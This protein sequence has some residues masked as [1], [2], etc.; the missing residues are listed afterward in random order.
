MCLL[1]LVG[2]ILMIIENEISFM[3]KSEEDIIITCIIKVIITITTIILAALVFYYHRL[4]FYLYC[5]NNALD[6]WRIGLMNKK[7]FPIVFE[8]IVCLIHPMPRSFPLRWSLP[9]SNLA[10]NDSSSTTSISP[11]HIDIDVVLG[12]PSKFKHSL[13]IDNIF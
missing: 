7:I 11:H 6:N 1:G 3:I 2:I 5:V 12:L 13:F 8:A 9:V 4:N 10:N